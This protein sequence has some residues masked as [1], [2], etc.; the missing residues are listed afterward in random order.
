[1][2]QFCVLLLLLLIGFVAATTIMV[3]C[4]LD[5]AAL[6]SFLRFLN[7]AGIGYR[8]YVSSNGEIVVIPAQQR[9]LDTL[10][11]LIIDWRNV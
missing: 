9:S 11:V 10:P 2:R 4:D 1:M 3:P 5:Q 8:L 7:G 6:E